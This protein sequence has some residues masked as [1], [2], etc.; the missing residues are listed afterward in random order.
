MNETLTRLEF[1]GGK[2]S[3][4]EARDCRGFFEAIVPEPEDVKTCTANT[5]HD[6]SCAL[7]LFR[8]S[9][10]KI[11]LAHFRTMLRSSF[12]H[13]ITSC[14]YCSVVRPLLSYQRLNP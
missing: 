9:R 4:V 2:E 14:S 12:S 5:W 7:R 11:S 3:K 8:S 10:L 13:F 1:R 6:E